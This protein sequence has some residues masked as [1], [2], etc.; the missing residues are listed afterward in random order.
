[1][2]GRPHPSQRTMSRLVPFVLGASLAGLAASAR[3]RAE[4]PS[5][6]EVSEEHPGHRHAEHPNLV[7][8]KLGYVAFF[9]RGPDEVAG[10]QHQ[11]NFYGGLFYER[12]VIHEWLEIEL[13][14]G[15]TAGPEEVSLPID[16]YFKKPFH[17]SPRA[18]NY[19]GAGPVV[20]MIF[21]P[22]R[23]LLVGGNLTFGAYLWFSERWGL[24]LDLDLAAAATRGE[25]VFDVLVA[26]GPTLR[27]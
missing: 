15:T 1:M 10:Y 26:T 16:L 24:D 14:V 7:G 12:S 27:F 11:P 5:R 2:R 20:A 4:V 18:T 3:A 19:V 25:V 22:E 21:R 13:A 17:P 9:A 8:T 6:Q 23:R